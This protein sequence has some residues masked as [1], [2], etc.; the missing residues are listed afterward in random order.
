MYINLGFYKDLRIFFLITVNNI[1][2]SKE[3]HSLSLT[4]LAVYW[5]DP[6]ILMK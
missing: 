5:T 3:A 4:L 1:W 2:L 6:T